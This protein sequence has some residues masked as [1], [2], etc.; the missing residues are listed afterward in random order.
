MG[1]S[2]V[3]SKYDSARSQAIADILFTGLSPRVSFPSALRY[4]CK[5]TVNGI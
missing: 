3:V 1:I 2:E 4:S 5:V